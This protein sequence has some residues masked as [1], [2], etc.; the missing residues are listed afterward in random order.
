MVS[1]RFEPGQLRF[2][3]D[4]GLEPGLALID[5]PGHRFVEDANRALAGRLVEAA[6]LCCFVTTA[7]RYAD[8]I[9]WA[10]LTR[11]RERGVP[12]MV[13]VNRLPADADDRA[14]GPE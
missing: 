5:A 10:V 7:T 6:D 11:V 8:R 3:E 2:V 12:L 9:P 1:L 4:A 13:V 14:A